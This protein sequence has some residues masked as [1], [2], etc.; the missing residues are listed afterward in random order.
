M[1]YSSNYRGRFAPS[2]TGSLHFGSLTAALS[3]YLDAKH[4]HGTWL[5]RMEDL[6]TPRCVIGAAD[7]ILR[8]LAAFGLHSD[9]PVLYQ[10]QRTAAY[11]AALQQLQT[12]GAIYP[13]C[14]TR[15]EIA[16]SAL[17]GIDGQIYPG[18]CRNGIPEGKEGRAWRVN[19]NFNLLRHSRESGNPAIQNA[20]FSNP[21]DSR[22]HGITSDLSACGL[23]RMAS[24]SI[25]DESHN[26]VGVI[27]FEDAL[28]GHT[29][30]YLENEIGDFVVKRADGLFA[31]QLAVVVDDAFQG[32]THIV[33]GA[34]LL[35]STPRQIYLQRLLGLP[36]PHYMHLPI[37]VNGQGEKLSKQT[38]AQAI[39]TD[40]VV[41]A[42]IS[43]LEFLQQ[44]PPADL[45]DGS[46]EEVLN[47]AVANWRLEQ[48]KSVQKI[49]CEG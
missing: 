22:F 45:R 6:D 5:V 26:A 40:N 29:S 42:L 4:H 15:K 36:T 28:Q 43:V 1:I 32:I 3:S 41:T 49:P 11:E 23:S 33:R 44:Q 8:T 7:D 31:Y 39:G 47:W 17:Y 9:E 20:F 38:L 48:L 37:A 21:L 27:S 35:H 16:D 14:C 25:N 10:S 34:D 18:T 19:T 2:P 12:I 13:C 30:Q 46:V 24:S